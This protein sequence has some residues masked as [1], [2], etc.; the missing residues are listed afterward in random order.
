M[1]TVKGLNPDGSPNAA[2]NKYRR[3][4]I[5]RRKDK[6]Q[7]TKHFNLLEFT[8]HD[9]SYVPVRAWGAI[10]RLCKNFLEPMRAKFGACIVLSGYRHR[11]YNY[12]IGGAMHSQHIYDQSPESIAA[13]TR[14]A[15]G[16]PKQWRD[17]ARTLRTSKN[18]GKGGIGTYMRSNFIHLDNRSYK[19]DWTGN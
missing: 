2:L 17:Y 12:A 6:G 11:A 8:C 19:A 4:Q 15:R 13:D 18:G 16:N 3:N 10:E 5:L 7:I 14:Y 1:S 9:G